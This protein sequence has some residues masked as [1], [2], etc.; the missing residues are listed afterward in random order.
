MSP[1]QT[2]LAPQFDE[3]TE[4]FRQC[5][6]LQKKNA[7]MSFNLTVAE[8]LLASYF[9]AIFPQKLFIFNNIQFDLV[10]FGA[11]IKLLSK[12]IEN[13]I[14]KVIYLTLRLWRLGELRSSCE[15]F[16]QQNSVGDGQ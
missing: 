16:K 14:H 1:K 12:N 9:L 3:L 4:T 11:G 8:A 7:R 6:C 13:N 5:F 15:A 2:H 10:I